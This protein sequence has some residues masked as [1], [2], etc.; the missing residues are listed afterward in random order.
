VRGADAAGDGRIGV[1]DDL[2]ASGKS[3]RADD[4]HNGRI[5]APRAVEHR[6]GIPGDRD[7]PGAAA[8]RPAGAEPGAGTAGA[9]LAGHADPWHAPGTAGGLADSAG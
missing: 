2:G 3:G 1:P 4:D 8:P 9:S 5:G 6:A 7:A